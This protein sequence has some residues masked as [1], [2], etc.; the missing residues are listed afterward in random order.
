MLH[1]KYYKSIFNIYLE[2]IEIIYTGKWKIF[3]SFL[4]IKH[5]L[6]RIFNQGSIKREKFKHFFYDNSLK[7]ACAMYNKDFRQ[8]NSDIY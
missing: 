6:G 2:I 7:I 8:F 5:Y 3:L 1:N 4:D